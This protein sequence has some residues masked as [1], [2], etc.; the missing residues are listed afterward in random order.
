MFHDIVRET[1][2]AMSKK[3][4]QTRFKLAAERDSEESKS[5]EMFTEVGR[6]IVQLSN[7]ENELASL[8]HSLTS[9][10]YLSTPTAMAVFYAQS[11][12][13]A[14]VLLVDL[15]MRIEGPKEFF[16]RWERIVKELKQHRPVRNLVAHQRL[17]VSYPDKEGRVN[18]SLDPA[19]L[20]LRYDPQ[21]KEIVPAKGR[22][23][24]LKEVRSTASA[25]DR[26]RRDLS[27]L[28]FDLDERNLPK[29]LRSDYLEP[30]DE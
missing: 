16:K 27:R 25:L 12:F 24:S 3:V 30:E 23:L 8:Y 9:G 4:R 20:N 10:H 7:I 17:Y 5:H 19:E 22:P 29:H 15:L 1:E 26:I 18:V 28:W 14:K 13:D 6:T 21:K 11:W 2:L